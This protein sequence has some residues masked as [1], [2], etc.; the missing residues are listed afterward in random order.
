MIPTRQPYPQIDPITRNKKIIAKKDLKDGY[1]ERLLHGAMHVGR[2]SVLPLFL[3]DLF[4]Q[5]FPQYTDES[6]KALTEALEVDESLLVRLIRASV[7]YH[8]TA[9]EDEKEDRWDKQSGENLKTALLESQFPLQ[10]A[11]FFESATA[12]K[13]KLSEFEK[14]CEHAIPSLPVLYAHFI[15]K[16]INLS[17]CFDT[18]HCRGKFDFSYVIRQLNDI[19]EY[20][21]DLHLPLFIEL[22]K[23]LHT[24]IWDQ[25]DMYFDCKLILNHQTIPTERTGQ[26]FIRPLKVQYEHAKNAVSALAA[27]MMTYPYFRRLL[28]NEQLLCTD[29]AEVESAFDPFVHGTQSSALCIVKLMKNRGLSPVLTSPQHLLSMSLAPM[30]GELSRHDASKKFTDSALL[31]FGRLRLITDDPS[32]YDLPKTLNYATE[33]AGELTEKELSERTIE[34]F[35]YYYQECLNSGFTYLH[36]FLVYYIRAKLLG[37]DDTLLFEGDGKK[38]FLET[39]K[40]TI[41]FYYL[42][43]LLHNKLRVNTYLKYIIDELKRNKISD[44]IYSSLTMTLLVDRIRLSQIDIKTIYENPT[45]ETLEPLLSFFELPNQEQFFYGTWLEVNMDKPDPCKIKCDFAPEFR[46]LTTNDKHSGINRFLYNYFKDYPDCQALI[47][48]QQFVPQHIQHLE[49]HLDLLTRVFEVNHDSLLNDELSR[50]LLTENFPILFLSQN[51]EAITISRFDTQEFRANRPLV[52]GQDIS[53]LATNTFENAITL[54]KFLVQHEFE[55]VGVILFSELQKCV[56]N[57]VR[58][59]VLHVDYKHRLPTLAWMAAKSVVPGTMQRRNGKSTIEVL[60]EKMQEAEAHYR[61]SINDSDTTIQKMMQKKYLKAKA[62][63]D[64]VSD[65]FCYHLGEAEIYHSTIKQ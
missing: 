51:D 62:D 35:K 61:A 56:S 34:K 15:R 46:E 30:T 59:K 7:I 37:I 44:L 52:F 28:E 16:I 54:R 42:F 57:T 11:E 25:G 27:N 49:E 32:Q 20:S 18:M 26:H 53:L 5:C 23:Q 17:D 58:P 10:L 47:G 9:R 45:Q 39:Y 40:A 29:L 55:H 36:T 14:Y 3:I 65:E 31:C 41:Q 1:I 24:V 63:Y 43:L 48:T 19:P 12:N 8:D 50:T 2:A 13:D 4:R 22:G 60:Y 6:F 38:A 21:E 33:D 64:R